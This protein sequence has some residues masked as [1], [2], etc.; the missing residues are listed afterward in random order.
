MKVGGDMSLMEN[1]SLADKG[2]LD[3]EVIFCGCYRHKILNSI[4]K[5][6]NRVSD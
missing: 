2:I 1:A 3:S 6:H 4:P 5:M